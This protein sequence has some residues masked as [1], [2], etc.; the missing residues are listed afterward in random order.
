MAPGKINRVK[1]VFVRTARHQRRVLRL[2]GAG[3]AAALD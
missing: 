1:K 3:N 2:R